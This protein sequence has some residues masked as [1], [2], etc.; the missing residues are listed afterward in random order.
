M[1]VAEAKEELRREIRARR[2]TRPPRLRAEASLALAEVLGTVPAV[3][4]A[5]VIATYASRPTEPSTSAL[6]E[7]LAA[8]GARILLPVLGAGLARDWAEYTGEADLRERAPG[9]PPEPGGPT[10]GSDAIAEADVVVAPALAVDTRGVRLGQGGGWYDRSLKRARPGVPVVVMVFPEEVY[11]GSERPLPV[12]D[13]DMPVH[14]VA[15]PE[16]WQALPA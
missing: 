2:A 11:D 8:R 12:E 9:R 7:Q 16:G 13:H 3:R 14:V 5:E 4:D 1:E 6:L 10:L 15:T